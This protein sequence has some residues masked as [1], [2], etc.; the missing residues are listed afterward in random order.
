MKSVR[1]LLA[2]QRSIGRRQT[3]ARLADI[4]FDQLK[5]FNRF[6][7]ELRQASNLVSPS[8]CE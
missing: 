2:G 3:E 6:S 8:S 4:A 5:V 1:C 7:T